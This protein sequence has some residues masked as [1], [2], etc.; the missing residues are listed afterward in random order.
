MLLHERKISGVMQQPMVVL[1]A[2]CAD[3]E[4]CSLANRNAQISQRAVIP[5]D[6]RREVGPQKRHDD[7]LA[8]SS[9]DASGVGFV[10]SALEN[11]E[12]DEVTDQK[13]FLRRRRFPVSRLL[14]SGGRANARSRQTCRRESWPVRVATLTH[15]VQ[16]AYPAQSLEHRQ[17]F[18][19]LAYPNQQPKAFFHR[20]SFGR[21]AGRRHG[22][23]HQFVIDFDVGPH[24]AQS[25]LCASDLNSTHRGG[26]ATPIQS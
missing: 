4:V 12:Q 2:E 24:R 8:Q 18:G 21:K 17:R 15:L 5:S 14:G 26:K 20:C 9:F 6:S 25:K 19:L 3:D 7:I 13:R 11:L 16:L 22:L 1:D 23:R 10:P